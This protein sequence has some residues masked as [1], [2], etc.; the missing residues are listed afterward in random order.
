M[1]KNKIVK[2]TCTIKKN[3]HG[4]GCQ[5]DEGC[6]NEDDKFVMCPLHEAAPELLQAVKELLAN[7]DRQP[8]SYLDLIKKAESK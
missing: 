6:P 1:K 4:W 7:K 2:C 8:Q 3:R 5:C